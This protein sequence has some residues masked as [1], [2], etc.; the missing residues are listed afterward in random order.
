MAAF[1]ELEDIIK[2]FAPISLDEMKD[3]KLMNRTDTKYVIAI[4]SL[5][6]LL[7]QS[8]HDYRLQEVNGER[9]I[10]YHTIYYDT[11]DQKMYLTHQNGRKTREKI[12][13]RTYVSSNLS[14][15]EVKNKNN[16]GRTDKK[17][18]KIKENKDNFLFE[19]RT[20]EFLKQNA[21]FTPEELHPQ[22]ENRFNR[23]T[24]VNNGMTERLTIDTNLHFH[25]LINGV[26][27]D[28][29]GVAIVE[30]KR[31]GRTQSPMHDLFM[32]MHIH[33]SGFSKYVI[34]YALTDSQ[35][36]QNLLKERIRHILKINSKELTTVNN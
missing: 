30:L 1:Q 36:K 3:I 26:E 15:F 13:F 6:E 18:I 16:H 34:G 10:A 35:L 22:V 11:P 27:K 8:V 9:N 2:E 31:D 12:R 19:E 21:L 23:L 32:R 25:N 7:R 14:F 20:R 29:C 24:L 5:V 33:T 4:S 28:L 17:R